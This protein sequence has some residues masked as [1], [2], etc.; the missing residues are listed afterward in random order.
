[1]GNIRFIHTQYRIPN[2]VSYRVHYEIKFGKPCFKSSGQY[3]YLGFTSGLPTPRKKL[4]NRIRYSV[5]NEIEANT[6]LY[7]NAFHAL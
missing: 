7:K 3:E 5:Q 2:N 1:M 6:K 4:P